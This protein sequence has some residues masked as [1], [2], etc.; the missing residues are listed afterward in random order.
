M[1]DVKLPDGDINPVAHLMQ[2]AGKGLIFITAHESSA[3][4]AKLAVRQGHGQA[5]FGGRFALCSFCVRGPNEFRQA[6]EGGSVTQ[7]GR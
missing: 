4:S 5:L 6:V 7:L 2:R 3:A 1:L